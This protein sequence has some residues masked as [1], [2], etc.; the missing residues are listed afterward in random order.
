MS[1]LERVTKNFDLVIDSMQGELGVQH[2]DVSLAL[3]CQ[4]MI[5]VAKELA[6]LND[7]MKGNKEDEQ[8]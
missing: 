2:Q 4:G 7:S 1:E 6:I 5:E 8:C 3:I